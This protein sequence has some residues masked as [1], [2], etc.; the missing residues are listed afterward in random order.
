MKNI[1]YF[2]QILKLFSIF[3]IL[4][5]WNC[6]KVS[7]VEASDPL[8]KIEF[9]FLQATNKIFVSIPAAPSYQGSSIDTVMVLWMGTD[10]LATDVDT[11]GMNDTG[12]SGDIIGGDGIY[13]LK[14]L[15][16]GTTVK[17]VLPSSAKESI[18]LTIITRYGNTILS[19]ETSFRLG[20]IR[21]QILSVWGPDTVAKPTTNEDPNIINTV[22]FSV[23][24]TVTDINGL[25]DIRKVQFRSYHTQLDSFMFGGNPITLYDDG[26]G[27]DG[28]GDL[29]KGDGTY[30]ITV[31]LTETA[32]TGTY[33]WIFEAQDF[34]NAYSD[35]VTLV[36]VVE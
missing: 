21:P 5:G 4:A 27:S 33:H 24:C 3:L 29:Q 23:T 1:V 34:S 2:P 14:F 15:N 19:E 32:L 30:T 25:D 36:L 28:S 20:N 22:K 31:S 6:A 11:L 13:S 8:G 35:P 12:I 18:F 7:S 10:S 9:S 16:D 17:N 26:T